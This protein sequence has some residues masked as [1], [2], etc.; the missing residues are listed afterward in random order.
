MAI[1]FPRSMAPA[2]MIEVVYWDDPLLQGLVGIGSLNVLSQATDTAFTYHHW[3]VPSTDQTIQAGLAFE[4]YPWTFPVVDF[5]H[6]VRLGPRM[7]LNLGWPLPVHFLS[8]L[9]EPWLQFGGSRMKLGGLPVWRGHFIWTGSGV[10][11]D[12]TYPL[13]VAHL[14]SDMYGSLALE[15]DPPYTLSQNGAVVT[16]DTLRGAG[17][18]TAFAPIPIPFPAGGPSE[19]HTWEDYTVGGAPARLDVRTTI[20]PQVQSPPPVLD[21]LEIFANGAAS[22]SIPV[23]PGVDAGV[24]FKIP[25]AAQ[26]GVQAWVRLTRQSAWTPLTLQTDVDGLVGRFPPPLRGPVDL[27]LAAQDDTGH[28]IEFTWSPAFIATSGSPPGAG[29]QLAIAGARPNPASTSGF[30][31]A[32]TLPSTGPARLTLHDVAG[33]EILRRD[34]GALGPGDHLVRLDPGRTLRPGLYFLRLESSAGSVNSRVC[35]LR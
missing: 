16:E 20:D 12:T 35:L 3:F 11:L 31:V 27:R 17:N 33:R 13:S 32:F 8:W 15:P 24:R 2:A 5:Q 34:V 22:D 21:R 4:M 14:T 28:S 30:S 1:D 19:F 9:D 18:F 26:N 7:R 10:N 29:S 25:G 6:P 23:V